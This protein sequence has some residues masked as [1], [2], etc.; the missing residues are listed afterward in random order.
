MCDP[1]KISRLKIF[2]VDARSP[3]KKQGYRKTFFKV[4]TSMLL[5]DNG[6]IIASFFFSQGG[7]S[8]GVARIDRFKKSMISV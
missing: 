4:L 7:C 5:A 8:A 6:I 2:V 1:F 3:D